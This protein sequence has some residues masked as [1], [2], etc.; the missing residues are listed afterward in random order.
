MDRDSSNGSSAELA[1][2]GVQA[3]AHVEADAANVFDD[4]ARATDCSRRPVEGGEETV[5]GRV[6][7]DAP[8]ALEIA[9]HDLVVLLEQIAPAAIAKLT[10][11]IRRADDV[12]E[13]DRGEHSIRGDGLSDARQEF[14]DLVQDVVAVDEG[15]VVL[16]RE[17]HVTRAFDVAREPARVLDGADLV[18][19]AMDDERRGCDRRDDVPN[20]DLERHAH[21]G[22]G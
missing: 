4:R 10:C 11:S 18:A 20:I 13:Q 19:D 3:R 9:T 17:L 15:K 22:D 6:D 16:S 7:L 2:A 12:G 1:L 8:K 14:L 21:E 5:A